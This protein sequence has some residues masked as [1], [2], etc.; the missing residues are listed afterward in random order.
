[1]PPKGKK[2]LNMN[3]DEKLLADIDEYRFEQRLESRS[4]A[5]EE[6]VRAGLEAK[7]PR[8]KAK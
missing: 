3:I 7:R 2:V 5:I 8:K 6:L 4:V 1:M